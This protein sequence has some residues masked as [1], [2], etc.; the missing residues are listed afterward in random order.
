MLEAELLLP[1]KTKGRPAAPVSAALEK[2][3]NAYIVAAGASAVAA[4]GAAP[5]ASAEI[6]YTPAHVTVSEGG[7]YSIDLNGDGVSDFTLNFV[8]YASHG[9]DLALVLDVPGNGVR[10]ALPGTLSVPAAGDL[11][12]GALIGREQAYKTTTSGFYGGVLMGAGYAYHSSTFQFGPWVN[13]TH[14]YLGVKFMIGGEVHFGWVRL[15]VNG[16]QF[17]G[18]QAVITG[19]AYETEPDQ[20][21]RAGEESGAPGKSASSHDLQAE[22]QP[23]LGLL[24]LGVDGLDAWRH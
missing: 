4:L 14:R 19:Y 15:N 1:A 10:P 20:V 13:A 2:R 9:S 8:R 11:R 22:Q 5:S 21:I 17:L 3:L 24:A 7:S 12:V 18:G 6:V 23:T 16:L